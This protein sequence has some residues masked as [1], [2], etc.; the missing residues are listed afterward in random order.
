VWELRLDGVP[1]WRQLGVA[2]DIGL[3]YPMVFMDAMRGD[4]WAYYSQPAFTPL[5]H[6][7]FEADTVRATILPV[8]GMVP[9]MSSVLTAMSFDAAHERMIAF[10]F[11]RR[12]GVNA[13][14]GTLWT[15]QLG[16]SVT[17]TSQ[18]VPGEAPTHRTYFS[19]VYDDGSSRLFI[20]GGYADN[21]NYFADSW[22]LDF[23]EPTSVQVSL[24]SAVADERGAHLRWYVPAPVASGL[25]ERSSDGSAWQA[26]GAAMRS[27][28][29]AM[30]YDDA[31]LAPGVR[32]AYRLRITAGAQLTYTPAAWLSRAAADGL[33]LSAMPRVPGAAAGV[34]FTLAPGRDARLRLF[35]VSG[36]MRASVTLTPGSQAWTFRESL[37][38]GL[39]V[40]ELTQGSARRT[41]RVIALR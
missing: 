39:Y 29:D 25:V 4:G 12:G 16:D 27:G 3:P 22:Q 15:A 35:D 11:P 1:V 5:R 32:A 24:A 18:A 10:Y 31:T 37:E 34:A 14:L 21:E 20:T 26:L 2:G 30:T 28:T 17:W 41:A 38:P 23:V 40:A 19:S 13:D 36:R 9:E 33:A 6:L 8:R 7:T